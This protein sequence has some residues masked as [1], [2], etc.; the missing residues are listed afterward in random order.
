MRDKQGNT[1]KKATCVDQ[2]LLSYQA[3]EGINFARNVK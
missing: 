1:K 3:I 2:L